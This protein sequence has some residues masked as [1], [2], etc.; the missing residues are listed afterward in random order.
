MNYSVV[1]PCAG[2]GSRMGLDEN[3][4]FLPLNGKSII[5]HTVNIFLEDERCKQI[6]LVHMWASTPT[7][8]FVHICRGGCPHPPV[9][10]NPNG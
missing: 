2:K 4:I 5:E 9:A 6:I 8:S 1:I 3:K 10:S 7:D